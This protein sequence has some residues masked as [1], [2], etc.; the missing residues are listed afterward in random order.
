MC[1]WEPT[2]LCRSRWISVLNVKT[3]FPSLLEHVTGYKSK[4]YPRACAKLFVHSGPLEQT[5]TVKLFSGRASGS[6]VVVGLPP[7]FAMRHHVMMIMLSLVHTFMSKS[8]EGINN[9]EGVSHRFLKSRATCAQRKYL[10]FWCCS[11]HFVLESLNKY[12]L[13][14]CSINSIGAH[15]VPEGSSSDLCGQ[16]TLPLQVS[17]IGGCLSGKAWRRAFHLS[18]FCDGR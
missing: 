11:V 16:K 17:D 6:E 12:A 13:C 8:G 10:Q 4:S 7:W 2:T 18:K 5:R 3:C 14:I 9:L 15:S 1:V